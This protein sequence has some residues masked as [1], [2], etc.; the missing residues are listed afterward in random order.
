M[1]TPGIIKSKTDQ[2]VDYITMWLKSGELKVGDRL[3]SERELAQRLNVNLLTINKAMA[4]LEDAMLLSRSA[5]RGTHVIKLPSPEAI[6]IIFDI[7]H[8]ATPQQSQF[9][10]TLLEKLLKITA[11]SAM[12]PHFLIGTGATTQSF[13]GSLGLQSALWNNVTG[14]IA[15]AWR[16]GLDEALEQRGIPLVTISSK[17]QG[18]YSVTIDY[19]ELGRKAAGSIMAHQAKSILVVHN[20]IFETIAWN[21]PLHSFRSELEK[22]GGASLPLNCIS[23]APTRE[24][25]RKIGEQIKQMPDAILFT[26][27]HI[28]AGFAEW[29]K[30]QPEYKHPR[31]IITQSSSDTPL[32]L[33]GYFDRLE[34]DIATICQTAIELLQDAQKQTPGLQERRF[35]AP[36]LQHLGNHRHSDQ[37]L[38]TAIK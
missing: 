24:A 1:N 35:V 25:G 33:P 22:L 13:L 23:A 2:V 29:L 34:F 5:G 31:Y 9:N 6:A 3:P 28:A 10:E 11:A 27:E 4:R 17:D 37:Q 36:A 15:M 8:L 7:C 21:N 26:D 38:L 16:S 30:S 18:K 20:D 32:P 19:T 14:A 12:T